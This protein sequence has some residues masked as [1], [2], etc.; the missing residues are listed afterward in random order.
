VSVPL[1]PEQLSIAR[2]AVSTLRRAGAGRKLI[3][4]DLAAGLVESNL[5]PLSG[6]DRD[7]T[8]YLQQRPSMGWGPV[9]E[10]VEQDTQ[11]FLAAARRVRQRGFHGTAGQLAQAVQRSGFPDRY[12][13]RLPEAKAL[14]ARLGGGGKV[15][16]PGMGAAIVDASGQQVPL[17]Q[18]AQA[19]QASAALPEGSSGV[20][21]LVAALN[22]RPQPVQSMGLQ[23]PAFSAQARLPQGFGQVVSGGGPRPKVDVGALVDAVRTHGGDVP[24]VAAGVVPAPRGVAAV[25]VGAAQGLPRATSKVGRA[26]GGAQ[27]VVSFDGKPVAAWMVPALKYARAHGWSGTVVSGVRTRAQ[28]QALWNARA[29]NPFPV[30][31]PGSSNHEIENGGAIDA[32]DPNGLAEALRGFRGPTLVQGLAIR[33]PVHFSRTGR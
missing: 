16:R 1:T 25:P 15:G 13:E 19:Q 29:S 30:A 32:S 10:S 17:Q 9:G 14:L 5:R 2:R 26:K 12:D 20:A 8:G 22:Q 7:S 21:G 33:D 23:A 24:S 18:I 11:Q 3:L 27:G 6:G 4:A 28:Q 31:R